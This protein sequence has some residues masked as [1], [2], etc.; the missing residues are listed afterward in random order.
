MNTVRIDE[1]LLVYQKTFGG[2]AR[3]GRPVLAWQV[4]A[5]GRIQREIQLEHY[6][7]EGRLLRFLA[8]DMPFVPGPLYFFVD[9]DRLIFK[10]TLGD[11]SAGGFA[12]P[13]PEE[14]RFVDGTDLHVIRGA[15]A[16]TG[17][18]HGKGVTGAPMSAAEEERLYGG[19]REAPRLRAKGDRKLRVRAPGAQEAIEYV[20]FDLSRGGLAFICDDGAR[21]RPGAIIHVTE[22]E[23][24]HLDQ[25]LV[26]EVMSVR[27][28]DGGSGHKVGVKFVQAA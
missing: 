15:A 23:G 24:S 11:I 21:F 5:Q 8:P 4:G 2:L 12:V 25:P 14:I 26:G 16:F 20:L 3:S 19:L 13:L 18:G 22:V 9:S 6:D 10:T 1:D 27:P 28:L 7:Y 17:G